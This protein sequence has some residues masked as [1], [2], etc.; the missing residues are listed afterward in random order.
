M[1]IFDSAHEYAAAAAQVCRD[2]PIMPLVAKELSNVQV[3][4]WNIFCLI[5]KNKMAA[6]G[7][8]RLPARSF[9]GS[10]EQSVL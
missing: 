5:L 8:F 10:Q 4:A 3:L 7:V 1:G 9:V 6:M 2:F